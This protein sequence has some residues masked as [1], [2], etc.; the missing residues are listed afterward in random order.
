[1]R[2]RRAH[3]RALREITQHHRARLVREHVE[4][5]EPD[6]DRLDARAQFLLATVVLAVVLVSGIVVGGIERFGGV[7]ILAD[8]TGTGGRRHRQWLN[9]ER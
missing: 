9:G 5:T 2:F 7:G 4:Q 1:M 3:A 8:R 6:F